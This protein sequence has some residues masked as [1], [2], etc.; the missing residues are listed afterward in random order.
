MSSM[1][2][3]CKGIPPHTVVK[4]LATLKQTIQVFTQTPIEITTH[5]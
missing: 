4:D 3:V 1:Q 2:P 5:E